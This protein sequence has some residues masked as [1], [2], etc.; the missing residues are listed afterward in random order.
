MNFSQKLARVWEKNNSLVCVGLDTDPQKLPAA[1]AGS[2]TPILDFNR[3][4]ID[5][6]GDK[7]CAFKLQ[8]AFYASAGA[9]AELSETIAY[10]K[11]KFP[12]VIVILDA[13]RGDIGNTAKHYAVEAFERFAADAVTV[14][15]Y[16]GGDSLEPF[17]NYADRGV[18]ILCRTSNAGARDIQDLRSDGRPIYLKVAELATAKW[19]ANNNV[20]L[21]VGA[22]YPEELREI[23]ECV[24]DDVAFLVP[25]VG[26]QGGDVGKAVTNGRNSRGNGL[27][28]SSS[29]G[30]IYASMGD[31]FAEAAGK[32]AARLRDEINQ[33]R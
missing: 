9:E 21:V 13:K 22:T 14:N 16:M 19:N 4:I 18:I 12:D 26:A 2:K 6:T 24:G 25:G 10:I 30:I 5:A 15:P 3:A 31:D 17:L 32:E 29:R 11:H 7:I 33:Y 23:R 1:I 20:C 27:I 8:I 28:V